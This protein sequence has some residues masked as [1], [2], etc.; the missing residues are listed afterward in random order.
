MNAKN[1]MFDME[2]NSNAVQSTRKISN[3]ISEYSAALYLRISREKI[4][5]ESGEKIKNSVSIDYQREVLTKYALDKGYEIYGEYV[6]DGKSGVKFNSKRDG[7]YSMIEDIEH[8][9]VNMVIAGDLSRFG[10]NSSQGTYYRDEFFPRHGVRF[11]SLDGHFDSDKD[12][13]NDFASFVDGFNEHYA[14]TTSRKVRRSRRI[15]AEKGRFMGSIPP[16]GYRRADN[17][18]HLLVVDEEVAHIVKRIFEQFKSGDSARRIADMLNND[19]VIPP[20]THYYQYMDKENPYGRNAK[21]WCSATIQSILQKD[22][23]LGHITQGKRRVRSYKDDTILFRPKEEW[24]TVKDTHTPIIDSD[25]FNTVQAIISTNNKGRQRRTSIGNE[26]R[27][28]CHYQ[29]LTKYAR[30]KA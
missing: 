21:T 6:D 25:T 12:E 13:E 8:G 19:G 14:R 27:A 4:D 9:H 24:I 7:F 29:K 23:Y 5:N 2:V 11:I 26:V 18:R 3:K 10:R 17:N 1:R 30:M 20:Q 22:V 15:A 16:Y 28:C